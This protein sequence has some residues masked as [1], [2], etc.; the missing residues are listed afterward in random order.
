MLQS[1]YYLSALMLFCI[2]VSSSLFAQTVVK[3]VVKNNQHQSLEGVKVQL[4]FT[5]RQ[6]ITDSLGQ[7]KLEIPQNIQKPELLVQGDGFLLKRY[8]ISKKRVERHNRD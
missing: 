4:I 7:F 3:G 5:E 6:T 1:K 8:Q 2:L